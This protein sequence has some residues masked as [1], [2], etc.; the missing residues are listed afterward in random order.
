M[1][2]Y[3]K[4][5]FSSLLF[6]S[7]VFFNGCD[8]NNNEKTTITILGENSSN[9]QAM[10]VLKSEYEKK[11][12]VTID[13][14]P[15]TFENAFNKA[16]QDFANKTGQYD[17]VLQYNFSLSSFVR[18]KFVYQLSELEDKIPDSLRSFEKD[19]FPNAWKEVGYYYKN[20]ENPTSEIT[21][22]GYPFAANTMVMVYNK[23]LFNNEKN[24]KAFKIKYKEELLVPKDWNQFIKVAEFFTKE[25][26]QID[27]N[28]YGVC[29]QG[30]I[31]GWLYYEFC[32]YLYGLEG[33]VM[34]K[35]YGWEGNQTTDLNLTS[36]ESIKATEFYIS[37][38]EY[39]AG[40]YLTVDQNEQLKIIREGNVAMAFVWSDYLYGLAYDENGNANSTYGFVPIPG[41]KSALAGGSFYIN[42]QSKNPVE[43]LKYIM[44]LMQEENQIALAKIG[45]CSPLRTTYN[46]PEMQN[47]P[48]NDAL[49]QSLERGIYMFEAG[50]EADLINQTLTKYIQE[51]WQGKISVKQ[52]LYHAQDEIETGRIEIYKNL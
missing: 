43:A 31:G 37:M 26:M 22:I 14:K 48:Y 23:E 35:Q 7:V 8:S 49:K 11:N 9:L 15:N 25:N 20:P 42:Q 1:N 16:N 18:N 19:L 12:N 17:I 39:N 27:K 2:K 6:L 3:S 21:Q 29:M 28:T 41:N 32:N 51:L 33:S 10:E 44:S 50:P 38:K 5:I 24:K 45:L 30:A 34:N 4:K 46:S 13:F 40:N 47:I 52:A 36:T